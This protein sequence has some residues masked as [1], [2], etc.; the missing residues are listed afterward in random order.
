MTKTVAVIGTGAAGLAAAYA[1]AQAGAHVTLYERHDKVGGTTALSGGVAWMPGNEHVDDPPERGLAYLA[2]LALGDFDAKLVRVFVHEAGA[3][4]ARLQRETHL[5]WSS[6]PYPDYHAEFDGGR[7]EGGRSLEPAA[8]DPPESV[9]A[10]V[11]DAPNRAGSMTYVEL[12]GSGVTQEELVRR[13]LAGTLTGGRALTA[14]LLAA[15]L[16]SGVDLQLGVRVRSLPIADAVVLATGGFERDA[17]LVRA[18]LRGPMLA[19]TGAPGAEGDGLRMAIAA[20]ALL[21]S[22]SEAW[23]CP[24]TH[25][26]GD[27]IDGAPMFRLLLAERA[28]PR[29]LMV[30]G[31]GRRFANEAQNYND[32]GRALQNFDPT[33]FSFPHVPAWLVFDGEYRRT[34]LLGPLT[35]DDPDPDW[36]LSGSTVE[37]LAA[38][39]RVPPDALAATIARFNEFGARGNDVDF[40]RGNQAYDRFV[41]GVG[42]LD[43]SPFYAL[44]VLPGCLGTKGGPRTDTFGRVQSIA[45]GEIIPGLYAAG[46][47]AASP[48]GLA[49]PG[50]GGTIGPALVFGLRAGEAAAADG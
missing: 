1:A 46:N 10:L 18:F 48:F 27:T 32:F 21:G 24:A 29:A 23:W 17:E 47:A 36:L 11:R 38:E 8:Y 40:G 20:G 15:C 16:D 44:A 25:I 22:M 26:P 34:Q 9:R 13:E 5:R 2:A 42:S 35:P 4:A 28:R 3:A 14:A 39:I 7:P 50:A 49:Y 37:E 43:E 12:W 30:D 33:T 31:S 41:G 45:T 6:L 19:P